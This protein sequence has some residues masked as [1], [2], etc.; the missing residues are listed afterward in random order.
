[1]MSA[2]QL[3]L[4]YLSESVPAGRRLLMSAVLRK[5]AGCLPQALTI[6]PT[7]SVLKLGQNLV[8]KNL[9]TLLQAC[10]SIHSNTEMCKF[11]F[12]F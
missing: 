4:T 1:M 10:F 8:N 12:N 2:D 3:S 5:R 11:L 7:H 9:M 6:P